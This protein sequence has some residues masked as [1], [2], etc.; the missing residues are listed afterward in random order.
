[1][2]RVFLQAAGLPL[3]RLR[4]PATQLRTRRPLTL[5][6]NLPLVG[7]WAV[8]LGI[9]AFGCLLNVYKTYRIAETRLQLARIEVEY[10]RQQQINT[11]L[12]YRI[13]EEGDLAQVYVWARQHNFVP[14]PQTVW[15]NPA[16]VPM[17]SSHTVTPDGK[18]GTDIPTPGERIQTMSE[19]VEIL[20]LSLQE[21]L[22]EWSLALDSFTL[23]PPDI[24]E[25]LP[26]VAQ[27]DESRS[28]WERL[29]D[30]ANAGIPD[31]PAAP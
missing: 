25:P 30:S 31:P 8:F 3:Q 27:E 2:M 13:G 12:L 1:M 17:V 23:M 20:G 16:P 21:R 7:W 15:L 4:K 5:A 18:P 22:L 14:Q 28:W 9:I 26:A 24:L 19:Y 10:T 29:L 11:E 6:F